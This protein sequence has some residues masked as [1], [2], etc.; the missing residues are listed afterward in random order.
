[1]LFLSME[2]MVFGAGEIDLR[3][4]RNKQTCGLRRRKVVEKFRTMDGPWL[5]LLLRNVEEGK[6]CTG[7]L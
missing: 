1:M 6:R 5:P 7:A 3:P 2:V 4:E